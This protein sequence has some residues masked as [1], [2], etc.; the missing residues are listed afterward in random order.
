M[1][2][3][4]E[5]TPTKYE[6]TEGISEDYR[7][8]AFWELKH[9][10]LREDQLSAILWAVNTDGYGLLEA[11]TGSGK[12]AIARAITSKKKTVALC[13]T[14][15]L[16]YENYEEYGFDAHYGREN[17]ECINPENP[18]S[19][20]DMCIHLEKGMNKC[21]YFSQC[22]YSVSKFKAMRSTK[23]SLNYAYW[24]T[25]KSWREDNPPEVLFLD[26]C[27]NIPDIVTNWT[28]CTIKEDERK[29][30]HLPE[31]P[32]LTY[33][34]SS[35]IGT[36]IPDADT[37]NIHIALAWMHKSASILR[38]R[39]KVLQKH[40]KAGVHNA[41]EEM[42]ECARIGY[43]VA[44]T[45]QAIQDNADRWYVESG[46]ALVYTRYG[47]APALIAKPL[48]ACMHFKKLFNAKTCILMSATIGNFSA[49]AKELGVHAHAECRVAHRYPAHARPVH[50][51]DAPRFGKN[52]DDAQYNMQADAIAKAIL[53]NNKEWSGLVLVT[54]KTEASLLA[55]RLARRGLQDRVWV[56]P[57]SDGKYVPTDTQVK[58]WADRRKKIPNSICITWAFWEGYNGLD[59]KICIVAKVPFPNLSTRFEQARLKANPRMYNLRTGWSLTQGLGRTRRGRDED[60]GAD[61]GYVAIADANWTR[62]RSS[63]PEYIFESIVL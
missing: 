15:M 11:P 14:K 63:L 10:S 47:Y 52:S 53:Q 59:E 58:A 3:F 46:D 43:K 33:T 57:G 41:Q 6:L 21:E 40:A 51:L 4:P 18:N 49:F 29:K 9:E 26:E 62:V 20:A 22:P 44:T 38:A 56:T 31:F 50:I 13:M 23:T 7:S 54:R 27:H 25:A 2:T 24:L 32:K 16:Q 8:P 17:F 60:Y 28:G 35:I 1:E 48:S 34:H 55:D 12:T 5:H 45:A 39:Y 42:H 30:W 61:N 37:D 19:S 36:F